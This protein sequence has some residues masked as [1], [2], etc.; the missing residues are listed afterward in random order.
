MLDQIFDYRRHTACDMQTK[1][2]GAN[3]P[4]EMFCNG[5]YIYLSRIMTGNNFYGFV[6]LFTGHILCVY[7]PFEFNNFPLQLFD[8]VDHLLAHVTTLSS[9]EPIQH[10]LEEL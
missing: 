4:N 8:P 2:Y 5:I 7:P 6:K 9:V 3:I 1:D 10:L